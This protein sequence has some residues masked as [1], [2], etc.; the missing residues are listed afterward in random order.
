MKRT[1]RLRFKARRT[2]AK[3]PF[4]EFVKRRLKLILILQA[5]AG[6]PPMEFA[7]GNPLAA[8][9]RRQFVNGEDT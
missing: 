6:P 1:W 4:C 7:R 3:S 2:I 9:S 8:G 5:M